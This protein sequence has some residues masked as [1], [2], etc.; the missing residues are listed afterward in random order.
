[1]P[2]PPLDP[3]KRDE[4]LRLK[5][6]GYTYRQISDMADVSIGM[7]SKIANA[8]PRTSR[9]D[10]YA[11]FHREKFLELKE[12]F[13][14]WIGNTDKIKA[15]KSKPGRRI[16]ALA[17]NDI[18]APMHNEQALAKAIRDNASADE[19]WIVGDFL[20]LFNFSRYVKFKRP[21]SPVQEFQAGQAILNVLA[22]SFPIVRVLHGNHDERFVIGWLGTKGF[23]RRSSSSFPSCI[24]ISAPRWP[25]CAPA[26]PTSR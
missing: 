11:E 12:R 14:T 13:N 19:C 25:R 3:H 10:E 17:I 9:I 23:H 15:P 22:E 6:K 24:L 18:H 16:K 2:I 20:D 7:V 26:S 8:E 5:A 21:F 4:V 1:M